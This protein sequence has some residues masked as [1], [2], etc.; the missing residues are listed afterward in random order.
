MR[1]IPKKPGCVGLL[2]LLLLKYRISS[3]NTRRPST[4]GINRGLVLLSEFETKTRKPKSFYYQN[5]AFFAWRHK[6]QTF[7]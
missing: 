6:E 4:A 3:Y 5:S 2:E 7:Q 1:Q